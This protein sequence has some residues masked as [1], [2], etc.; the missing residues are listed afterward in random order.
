[1]VF[2]VCSNSVFFFFWWCNFDVHMLL[3][4]ISHFFS[5][6]DCRPQGGVREKMRYNHGMLV[7]MEEPTGCE[8]KKVVKLITIVNS[9]KS[10]GYNTWM[11]YY[12]Y[13]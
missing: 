4:Q 2:F 12:I 1:M 8:L 3:L 5:P 9:S 7:A 13:L 10:L 11:V 6:C